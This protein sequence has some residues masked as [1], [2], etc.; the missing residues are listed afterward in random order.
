MRVIPG[1]A[2]TAIA[3]LSATSSQAQQSVNSSP[4]LPT[5]SIVDGF[6]SSDFPF[7]N[8]A[9]SVGPPFVNPPTYA[10]PGLLTSDGYPSG[11][12]S[13]PLSYKLPVF[14]NYT[15]RY[16]IGWTGNSGYYQL[17]S[18]ATIYNGGA[19]VSGVGPRNTGSVGY[20]FTIGGRN[21]IVTFDFS[22]QITNVSS[23]GGLIKI[24][25]SNNLANGSSVIIVNV[26]GS[27]G[28]AMNGNTYT[29]S[30]ASPSS[31][32]LIGTAFS[33]SYTSGGQAFPVMTQTDLTVVP[34]TFS[35]V[36]GLFLCKLADYQNDPEG[37]MNPTLS[38]PGFNPDFIASLK[39]L[40]PGILRLLDVSGVI[41][42]NATNWSDRTPTT[43]FSYS[44]GRWVPGDWG[45][46]IDGT[47]TYTG[48][49]ANNTPATMTD[50]E[51]W[52]G[53]I[54]NTNLTTTP[55][56]N[57]GG[58]GAYPIFNSGLTQQFAT[59]GGSP[60][61]G[62]VLNFTF[63]GSCITRSPY[64]FS[65]TVKSS[66]STINILGA[67]ITRASQ[68]DATLRTAHIF[69][70]NP[71]NGALTYIYN[72]NLCHITFGQSVSGTTTPTES[73]T[74]GY[75]AVGAL[76]AGTPYTFTFNAILQAWIA[77]KNYGV[78]NGWPFELQIALC[79]AVGAGC[80]LE[81]P[82]F[83]TNSS[84]TAL[85]QW[86]VAN[87]N[88]SNGIW[89]EYSNEVWN[90]AQYQTEQANTL[91]TAL[92]LPSDGER[93]IYGWYGLR[94]RQLMALAAQAWGGRGGLHR[95]IAFQAFAGTSFSA[96]NTYRFQGA[97]LCGTK[98]GNATYQNL[99][100]TDYNTS[101]NRPIDFA[102]GMSYATYYE[103]AVLEG[104]SILGSRTNSVPCAA[105][106]PN[107]SDIAC[108]TRAADDFAS[109]DTS[110]AFAWMDNDVRAGQ[111]NGRL[112]PQTLLALYNNIY[113]GWNAIAASYGIPIWVYEG[114]YEGGAFN[115]GLSPPPS[116]CTGVGIAASYCGYGGKIFN[117]VNGYKNSSLFKQLVTDQ[118]TQLLAKSPPHSLPAW[119]TFGGGKGQWSLFPADI[120]STPFQ[121]Y[122]AIQQF[123]FLLRRDLDPRAKDNSPIWLN[124]PA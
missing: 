21:P 12:L 76:P 109:G 29:I 124:N 80:W 85:A 25:A 116:L 68:F 61:T 10:Y 22:A 26:S 52:Q 96:N 4:G 49:A 97:D 59:L 56:L 3:L 50:G 40:K 107:T 113:P 79:N 53:Q 47:D 83:Y 70:S 122:N 42:S 31:F 100:G 18:G 74:L 5:H 58:R 75:Q 45:G 73:I 87:A 72:S 67:S 81:L 93:T 84:M 24:T 9:K 13:H 103:G 95:V 60:T 118:Y 92:G 104:F 90:F 16:V 1:L 36:S 35:G 121:S 57:I 20:N 101:P 119:Y 66:D 34:S 102:D 86:L 28:S 30:N 43:A 62:D 98:C 48:V 106:G 120:Y 27:V 23:D 78:G 8:L 46:S 71:G 55:T 77:A 88:L 39:A 114:G 37:C 91:G 6:D 64:T 63:A 94:F 82:L 15:G 112:G 11:A 99:V 69:F 44:Q 14:R 51:T 117:M 33:G 115:G 65:Y 110:E 123:N 2:I 19:H 105:G 111:Q 54:I 38:H 89:L 17:S 41:G 7:I 32:D 108:M